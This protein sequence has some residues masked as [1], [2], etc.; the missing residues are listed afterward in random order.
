M[1][2]PES[3]TALLVHMSNSWGPETTCDGMPY[4]LQLPPAVKIWEDI[5]VA[6]CIAITPSA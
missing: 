1:P 5:Y 4:K 2:N 6:R 3:A